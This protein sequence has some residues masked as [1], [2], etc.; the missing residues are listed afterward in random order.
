[1]KYALR[2]TFACGCALA[3]LLPHSAAAAQADASKYPVRP[4][5]VIV[6]QSPGSSIDTMSRVVVHEDGR[7]ARVSRW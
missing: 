2:I 6:A 5:R 3:A 7:A 1:M 4:V